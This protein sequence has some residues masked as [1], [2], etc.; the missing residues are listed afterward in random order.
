M[1]QLV[2][3]FLQE[4]FLVGFTLFLN[5]EHGILHVVTQKLEKLR[6][7]LQIVWQYQNVCQIQVVDGDNFIEC[8]DEEAQ[9]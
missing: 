8:V 2:V 7:K 5:L 4:D 1:N 9:L 6:R 3:C